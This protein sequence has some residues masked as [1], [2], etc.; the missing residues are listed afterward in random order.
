[1]NGTNTQILSVS[2][3]DSRILRAAA[4]PCCSQLTA[5]LRHF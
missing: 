4:M 5:L 2:G 3:A 1:M